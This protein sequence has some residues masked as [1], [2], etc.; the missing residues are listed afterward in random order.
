[1][2]Q[3]TNALSAARTVQIMQASYAAAA[4]KAINTRVHASL[5]YVTGII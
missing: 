2:L 5:C 3:R 1:M 4:N